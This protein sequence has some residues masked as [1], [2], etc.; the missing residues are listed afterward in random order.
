MFSTPG[1]V[2]Y[3][4]YFMK[5]EYHLPNYVAMLETSVLEA[6]S[7]K[8]VTIITSVTS[9]ANV[10]EMND[11]SLMQ[12]FVVDKTMILLRKIL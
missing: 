3:F 10:Q 4:Y 12:R 9:G 5:K 7:Q 2:G 11:S 6:L 1:T 8:K